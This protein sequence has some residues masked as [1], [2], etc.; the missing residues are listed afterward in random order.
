MKEKKEKKKRRVFIKN[1]VF[2]VITLTLGLILLALWQFLPHEAYGDIKNA[3]FSEPTYVVASEDGRLAVVDACTQLFCFDAEE[4]LL[5]TFDVSRLKGYTNA[6]FFKAEFD[7]DD[8]LYVAVA[9]YDKNSMI[10]TKEA[11]L[12]FDAAGHFV[13]EVLCFDYA[14]AKI[15]HVYSESIL[16]LY[17]ANGALNYAYKNDDK[18]ISF[19]ALDVDSHV[20]SEIGTYQRADDADA[21]IIKPDFKGNYYVTFNNGEVGCLARDGSYTELCKYNFEPFEDFDAPVPSS[22]AYY[23]GSLLLVVGTASAEVATYEDGELYSFCT[24]YDILN[25]EDL[26]DISEEEIQIYYY[27][28]DVVSL[29]GNR[30]ALMISDKVF[31]VGEDEITPLNNQYPNAF[32]ERVR[33]WIRNYGL[34][35]AIVLTLVGLVSVVGCLM[36]WHMGIIAKQLLLNIPVVAI[37]ILVMIFLVGK[38]VKEKYMETLENEL[39][40]ISELASKQ[41]DGDMLTT[42]T[43]L[44]YVEDGRM[45]ELTTILKEL[46]GQNK[47]SWSEAYS[48]EIYLRMSEY[49]YTMCANSGDFQ[50]PFFSMYFKAGEDADNVLVDEDTGITI[51]NTYSSSDEYLQADVPIYDSYGNQVGLFVVSTLTSNVNEI[52]KG[53]MRTALR[54]MIVC[55]PIL[56]FA[57]TFVSIMNARSLRKASQAV[58]KIAGGDFSARIKNSSSDEVGEICRGVNDMAYRLDEFFKTKDKN[59]K[60]YYKFVPEKFKELLHKEKFTDLALGDAESADLTVLFCDIRAFSLNS[61]MMTA[62]ENFEF[63]NVIYGKAGPIIRKHGGF[64]DKYIGDAV[65]ALFE[66]ADDAVAAGIELYHEVV[67]NP[68][69]AEALGVSSINI[70]IGIHSGMARIG[71]VGEDE[72]LSGTVISNTVNISSRL[73]SL[74]KAYNTAMLISKDTLDRMDDPDSMNMRYLG[75]V[76]VAGVNEVKAVYEVLDCLDDTRK[77]DRLKTSKDFREA[78]RLFHLGQLEESLSLF[79]QVKQDSTTDVALDMYISTVEEK[80]ASGDMEHNVFRFN[81]K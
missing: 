23:D 11:I 24:I 3:C 25:D 48:A 78:V 75:M 14:D 9:D 44:S 59:E 71:I 67:L 42:I 18:S 15:P 54:P 38:N 74:T 76:Q 33:L 28:S 41:I 4:K 80:L 69:T 36:K 31:I 70:G 1:P 68:K 49:E 27:F 63:V 60:F 53:V 46:V 21:G 57:L 8:N 73:E 37:C 79:K 55:I 52:V 65:M 7:A 45:R 50:L 35:P 61:E 6:G 32:P 40:A 22:V 30:A 19:Y 77:D 17:Y 26:G 5:Y 13:E 34:I 16:A 47:R 29:R 10:D 20:V 56:L 58:A 51:T 39:L 62:K 12:K 64:V 66:N 81:K 43:D 2:G 72:R